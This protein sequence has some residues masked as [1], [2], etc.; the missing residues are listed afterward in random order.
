MV[1]EVTAGPA[2][3]AQAQPNR[4]SAAPVELPDVA[5]G[6]PAQEPAQHRQGPDPLPL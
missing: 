1:A 6:E 2:P 4:A 3:A 5:E